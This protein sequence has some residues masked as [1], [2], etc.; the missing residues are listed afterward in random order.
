MI[1]QNLVRHLV[2]TQ[3]PLWKDLPI[4][5]VA[6]CGWDNKTF[7]LGK[8]MLIRMPSAADYALQV[9]KE[10]KWLP[11]LAPFLPLP[12]PAPL[13]IGEPAAGYSWKWSIYNWLEGET[14]ASSQIANLNDFATSL[15]Q[16]LTALQCIDA[17][18]GPLAGLH[19]FYRGGALAT[20]DAEV[21][22]STAILKSKI[23]VDS[24]TEIWETALATT[25]QGLPV[26]VHGDISAGNLLVQKGNLSAVID[27]GQLA[28]GDPACDLVIAWTLFRDESRKVFQKYLSLDSETW[29]R[30]RA[31]ALW[32]A[33]VVAAGLK[34][35][36][37]AES[38][39][40]L[41]IIDEVITDH[42]R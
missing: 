36:N 34:N 18:A 9:E 10:H 15:A 24:V 14:A 23:D 2:A 28:V 1:D 11:K 3:F 22:Q 5:P 39:Q 37:N 6:P 17:K 12:I 31:W 26:W 29:A 27:F 38:T 42:R 32:K 21:K 30:G 25:W 35:P 19:S 13:A 41:R 8:H 16:F 4:Q 40:C 33:M 7:R 20:Y